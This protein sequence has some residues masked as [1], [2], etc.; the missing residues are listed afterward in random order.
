[1]CSSDLYYIDPTTTGTAGRFRG[2][3]LIGPNSSGR[4]TRIGGNG[5]SIDE[6]TLSASNGNLHIDS[7][8]GYGLYLNHYSNGTIFMNNGGGH[9]F[10][11]TSLRAPIFYDYNNTNYYLDPDGT[12]VLLATYI[13]GHYYYTYNSANIM[14]RTAGNSD[15]GILLQNAGG[16]FKFQLYGDNSSNYGFLNGPWASWDLRKT[17]NGN[18]YMNNNSSYYLNTNSLSCRIIAL[19]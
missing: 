7:A 15:G 19:I 12:S 6:A 11:Y 13:G 18:L 5:G 8:N 4:Y 9:A 17:L 10:S 1:V 16:S 3:I 14:I 2:E